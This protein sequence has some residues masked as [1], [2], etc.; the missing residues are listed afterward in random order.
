MHHS[1]SVVWGPKFTKFFSPKVEGVVVER[2]FLRFL[3]CRS[4]PDI[5]A[6]KVESCQKLRQILDDFLPSQISGGGPSKSY[7]HFV[8]HA[9]RHVAWKKFCEDTP[10]SPEVIGARMLNFKP[11][12]KFSRLQF[13]GGPP[14][15]FGCALARLGQSLARVKI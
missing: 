2:V 4:F 13:F 11:N 14:S 9:S 7:T 3:I 10:T 5:F 1:I 6:I 12:F 8:T 15:Q